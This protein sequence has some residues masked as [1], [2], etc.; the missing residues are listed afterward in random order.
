MDAFRLAEWAGS[1]S[2]APPL[3]FWKLAN[4]IIASKDSERMHEL[5]SA[6]GFSPI[7]FGRHNSKKRKLIREETP[8]PFSSS[9]DCSENNSAI[10]GRTFCTLLPKNETAFF[11]VRDEDSLEWLY[12]V[13]NVA[14]IF[15]DR[16]NKFLSPGLYDAHR[17]GVTLLWHSDHTQP[18]S[19]DWLEYP[20]TKDVTHT[21]FEGCPSVMDKKIFY[22]VGNISVTEKKF[23]DPVEHRRSERKTYILDR[24]LDCGNEGSPIRKKSA[25]WSRV[26]KCPA[27]WRFSEQTATEGVCAACGT[28]KPIRLTLECGNTRLGLGSRCFEKLHMAREII[29]SETITDELLDAAISV[30]ASENET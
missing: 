15:R 23:V 1:Q 12:T 16:P 7:P 26:L 20:S 28:T 27:D 13:E 24:L 17:K 5:T 18:F 22:V 2:C 11:T 4:P 21:V 9:S 25:A 14:R 10:L 8:S 30:L 29:T 3:P 6:F 19:D